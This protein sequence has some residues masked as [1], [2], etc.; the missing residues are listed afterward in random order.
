MPRRMTGQSPGRGG[1]A[2]PTRR[3][4]PPWASVRGLRLIVDDKEARSVAAAAGAEH[5][6]TAGALSEAYLRQCLDL[7]TLGATLRDLSQVLW[8]SPA[9]VAEVLRLAREAKR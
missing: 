8:L 2:S 3:Y 6:G 4:S 1:G 5:L 9:V 7:G